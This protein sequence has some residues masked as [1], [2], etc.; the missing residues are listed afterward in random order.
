MPNSNEL[1]G[2]WKEI[3][4]QFLSQ[5]KSIETTD[6]PEK[7]VESV[8]D[9]L[10]SYLEKTEE[11][12]DRCIWE[13]EESNELLHQK[14][15]E[16]NKVKSRILFLDR[17]LKSLTAINQ[18]IT[19]LKN[20]K[21]LLQSACDILTDVH[22]Y[23]LVWVGFIE[24]GHKRVVPVA[25]SGF[26][27]GYLDSIEVTWDDSPTGQGPTGTAIKTGKPSIMR[28]ILNDPSFDPWRL[29]ALQRGYHSSVALPLIA[30]G[31]TYGALSIYSTRTDA[32]DHEEMELLTQIAD[33]I[34]YALSSIDAEERR[35]NVEDK[36]RQLFR[37][38]RLILKSVGEGIYGVDLLGN[39]TFVNPSA[40][41]ITGF[42]P[43]E[44]IGKHQHDI[45]H[46]TRPDG[47][48]YPRNECPIYKTMEDKTT[49]HIT[50]DVFWRK[51]GTSFPVEYT[52]TPILESGRSVG[53]VVVFKDITERKRAQK[54]QKR[55]TQLLESLWESAQM[56]DAGYEALCDH[57][58]NK[59]VEMTHSEY[60][61]YGFLNEEETVMNIYSWSQ[62]ALEDCGSQ[63]KPSEFPIPAAGVWG[64]VVSKRKRIILNDY[65][66]AEDKKGTP[67]G[68]VP[69]KRILVVPTFSSGKI[70]SIA[71]VANKHSDYTEEDA[72][73]L[74]AFM[75]NVQTL[76]D[77]M[78]MQEELQ[79]LSTA[80]KM[81]SDSIVITD[82][83]G[84]IVDVNE[85]TLHTFKCSQ[86]QLLG[87]K[88]S[89]LVEPVDQK[90][91]EKALERVMEHGTIKQEYLV[92]ESERKIIET[93]FS[94]M[95][96]S[97]GRVTGIVAVSRDITEQKKSEEEVRKQLMKFHFK[98]GDLYLEPEK[99]LSKSLEGFTDLLKVGYQGIIISRTP[100][101]KFNA[102]L[103][104]SYDFWWLA[105]KD[106]SAIAPELEEI[107][108]R[109]EDLSRKVFLIDR[110][111]YLIS[112]NNF[113]N[114]L[115]FIQNL[116]EIAYMKDHTIILSIDPQ[117]LDEKESRLLEKECSP[118]EPRYMTKL[119]E[120]LLDVMKLI[121]RQNKSGIKPTY[122]DVGKELGISKPTAR[123]RIR[124]LVNHGYLVESTQGRFKLV[125][126]TEKGR[127]L[128][129][130]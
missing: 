126:I 72:K 117:T 68:H 48:P 40:V 98:E 130:R 64:D 100:P 57:V 20:R 43:E 105:R 79:R 114:T 11:L 15:D 119:P 120:N 36:L 96:D 63:I 129:Y 44:L 6:S 29:H 115:H 81:S 118:I 128:F 94:L 74:E 97:N 41:K 125:E 14:I 38:N 28:D 73:Q 31:Y 50:S 111:D 86:E 39:T 35:K 116:R 52:V 7:R 87:K 84:N 30:D 17:V 4:Q 18:L 56:V 65:Q 9:E 77:R 58:L 34:A 89:E 33:S 127:E 62:K 99:T 2:S 47:S 24:E 91:A 75:S 83:E 124:R 26:E 5:L 45:L 55:F 67:D 51:D 104:G 106:E 54:E 95:T 122:T 85:A 60:A 22:E 53:A 76:M 25:Q 82:R 78:K 49:R 107:E 12:I 10:K 19:R 37:Q 108:S 102:D 112:N 42:K 113:E 88:F 110:L 69:L 8:E 90:K 101:E 32:F 109:I 71:T 3:K 61:F 16:H 46:H 1:E 13:L 93:K 66:N 80:L 23:R 27:E 21:E 121:F 123:K 92:S 59:I 103:S 70:V